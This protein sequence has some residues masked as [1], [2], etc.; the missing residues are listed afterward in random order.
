MHAFDD[1][2]RAMRSIYIIH[3]FV[4]YKIFFRSWI[5]IFYVHKTFVRR[6]IDLYAWF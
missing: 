5:S 2:A 1:S 4:N 3:G 6:M